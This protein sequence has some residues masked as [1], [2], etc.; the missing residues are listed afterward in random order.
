MF[1]FDAS[2]S[3]LFVTYENLRTVYI[4][5]NVVQSVCMALFIYLGVGEPLTL[6][7]CHVH[8]FSLSLQPL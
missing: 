7:Q 4:V 2:F 3:N 6:T 5:K 8:L 1:Q